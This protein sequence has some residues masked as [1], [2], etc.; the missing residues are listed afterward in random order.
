MSRENRLNKNLSIQ[1]EHGKDYSEKSTH[2]KQLLISSIVTGDMG[3]FQQVKNQA[4]Q[5]EDIKVIINEEIDVQRLYIA[6]TVASFVE[7][8]IKQ[9]LPKDVAEN[10]KR[11]YFVNIAHCDSKVEL[12]QYYY[13]VVEELIT[14]MKKYSMKKYSPIVKM[15]IENIHNNKFH[16]IFAKDIA[17]AINSNRSYLS[18]K[19]KE[20]TESTIT[21][22]IH[23]VKIDFAIE[24]METNF[25]KFNEVA[26]LLGYTSY[27]Y[28]SRVFKKIYKKTPYE[29]ME[30]P[31]N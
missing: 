29:Y 18:K 9:G 5:I 25:Y 7:I 15:A 6:S 20:E 22:Y 19:F 23:K 31:K 21:D 14:G 13:K 10:A 26:D 27:S 28:F 8:A 1:S 17:L 3:L 11:K 12:E 16:S 24:L 4:E 30:S 2:L